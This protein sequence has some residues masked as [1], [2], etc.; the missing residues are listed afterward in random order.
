MA[1]S[2]EF[3]TA[4]EVATFWH[5][6]GVIARYLMEHPELTYRETAAT[7]G[8]SRHTVIRVGCLTRIRRK[9]GPKLR[10]KVSPCIGAEKL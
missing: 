9:R 1:K 8:V 3:Q 4:E 5:E 10:M 7:L 6:H 2:K